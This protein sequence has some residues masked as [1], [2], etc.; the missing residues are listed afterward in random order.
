MLYQIDGEYQH[1][2]F[3]ATPQ[4]RKYMLSNGDY[5]EVNFIKLNNLESNEVYY[6]NYQF[7]YHY[8]KYSG[9]YLKDYK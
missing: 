2:P 3:Y 9:V 6:Y 1:F 7:I 8:S 4:A 5:K